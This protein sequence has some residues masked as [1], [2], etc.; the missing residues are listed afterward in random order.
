MAGERGGLLGA[1]MVE[2]YF[3]TEYAS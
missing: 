2:G 1:V 3:E